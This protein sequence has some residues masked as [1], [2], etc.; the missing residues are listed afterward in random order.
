MKTTMAQQRKSVCGL[1]AVGL[2]G[3]SATTTHASLSNVAQGKLVIGG[4]GSWNNN[5]YNNSN[6]GQDFNAQKVTDNLYASDPMGNTGVIYEGPAATSGAHTGNYWLGREG[7]SAEYF[8]LDLGS[9]IDINHFDFFNTG[10]LDHSLGDRATG[11]FEI[12]GDNSVTYINGTVEYDLTSPTLLLSGTLAYENSGTMT[13][14]SFYP[15]GAN[16]RYLRFNALSIAAGAT[17]GVGLN[18]IR[19]FEN[20]PEPSTLMLVL[21]GAGTLAVAWRRHNVRS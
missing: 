15:G 20:V 6:N 18:E 10:N 2:I 21:L 19:V 17:S 12:Y 7:V 5:P 3:L 1:L 4:S 8:V 9:V 16:Y 13:A 14:Q 11:N